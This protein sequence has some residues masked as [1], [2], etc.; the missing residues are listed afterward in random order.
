M[1]VFANNKKAHFLYNILEK[2]EAGIV[3]SGT[4]VKSIVKNNVNITEAFVINKKDEAYVINMHVAPYDHGNIMNLDPLRTRKLLL[5]KNEIKKIFFAAKKDKLAVIVLK[6]YLNNK[7]IKL[8]I[9]LAK[10]KK[11]YDK[12]E[13]IKER[14]LQREIG[15]NFK[16][17]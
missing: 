12:R 9:A 16:K 7:K 15:K 13:T 11:I 1:K 3:L 8:E 6:I 14:D 17:R 4:E 10:S 2:Y 5:H